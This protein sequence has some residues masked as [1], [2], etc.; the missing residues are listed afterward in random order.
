V[1]DCTKL[2]F[3]DVRA[4]CQK[5]TQFVTIIVVMLGSSKLDKK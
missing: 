4:V 5:L 1:R 3:R 2:V